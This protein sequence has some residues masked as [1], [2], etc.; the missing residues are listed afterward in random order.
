MMNLES[1]NRLVTYILEKENNYG[2]TK[3]EIELLVKFVFPTEEEFSIITSNSR[4]SLKFYSL[5]MDFLG[6]SSFIKTPIENVDDVVSNLSEGNLLRELL[7][8][9][10]LINSLMNFLKNG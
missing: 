6:L 9:H 7:K 5:M 1:R 10:C 4:M 3:E 8:A 2:F